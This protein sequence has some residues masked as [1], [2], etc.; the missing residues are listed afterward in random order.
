MVPPLVSPSWDNWHIS[1]WRCIALEAC[2]VSIHSSAGQQ[3]GGAPSCPSA[4]Q[5]I[6][7]YY[8]WHP[9]V[10]PAQN[11]VSCSRTQKG[12]WRSKSDPLF[13]NQVFDRGAEKMHTEEDLGIY[14]LIIWYVYMYIYFTKNLQVSPEFLVSVSTPFLISGIYI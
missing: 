7:F 1:S 5:R 14:I 4:L 6:R 2:K 8:H 13:R 12:P 10:L 11:A 9:M 3:G